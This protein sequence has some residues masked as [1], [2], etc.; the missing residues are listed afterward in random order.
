MTIF[1][2]ILL[3]KLIF[4]VSKKQKNIT[5]MKCKDINNKKLLQQ[6]TKNYF[7][8]KFEDNIILF[9]IIDKTNAEGNLSDKEKKN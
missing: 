8:G 2:D 7:L 1:L 4:V 9:K 3:Q 6:I 5:T